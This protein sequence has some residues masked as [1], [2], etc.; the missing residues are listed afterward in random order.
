MKLKYRKNHFICCNHKYRI[1]Y[2]VEHDYNG[3]RIVE[4]YTFQCTKCGK[5]LDLDMDVPYQY[6][7]IN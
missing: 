7:N 6:R 2:I 4:H 1:N 3:R 5:I